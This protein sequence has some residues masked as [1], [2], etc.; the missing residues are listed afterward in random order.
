MLFVWINLGSPKAVWEALEG[1]A[2]WE[3]ITDFE[4]ITGEAY[5]LLPG[6]CKLLCLNLVLRARSPISGS[7]CLSLREGGTI[8]LI[9]ILLRPPSPS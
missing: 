8:L 4:S 2:V 1:L 3:V 5:S 7:P 9:N 6:E